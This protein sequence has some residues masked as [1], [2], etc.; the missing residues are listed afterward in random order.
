M[1][2]NGR[3]VWL[4]PVILRTSCQVDVQH[5][6]FDR[7]NCFLRF[8]SWSYDSTKMVM[9]FDGRPSITEKFVNSS[10][11]TLV[12]V[13]Q[14]HEHVLYEC[15]PHYFSTITFNVTLDRKPKYY[16]YH[17]VLP[18]CFQVSCSRSVN[19]VWSKKKVCSIE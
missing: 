9:G 3:H 17:V 19:A 6:P 2:H 1:Y 5:F 8:V 7:Q 18:C 14:A 4:I 16:L 12:G 11:W 15:C 10:E 13:R